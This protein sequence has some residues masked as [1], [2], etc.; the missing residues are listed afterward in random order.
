MK[1]R[2]GERERER[3]KEEKERK[4]RRVDKKLRKRYNGKGKIIIER[5]EDMKIDRQIEEINKK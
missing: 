1:G 3:E 2:E 5:V 4:R